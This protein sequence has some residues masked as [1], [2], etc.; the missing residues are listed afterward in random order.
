MILH[1]KHVDYK[2]TAKI[3][4]FIK[5]VLDSVAYIKYIPK[6]DLSITSDVPF[7]AHI[8]LQT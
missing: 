1:K 8:Y 2:M 3:E 5:V 4:I 7:L 6:S